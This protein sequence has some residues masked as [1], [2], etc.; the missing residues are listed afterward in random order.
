VFEQLFVAVNG[1]PVL[2][3]G[4][5][6]AT[7]VG[8][9]AVRGSHVLEL[10]TTR[11]CRAAV[12][13]LL[14]RMCREAI[15]RGSRQITFHSPATD[16]LQP[17]FD[18]AGARSAEAPGQDAPRLMAQV[19]SPAKLLREIGPLFLRRVEEANL[20]LPVQWSLAL[21]RRNYLITLDARGASVTAGKHDQHW[22]RVADRDLAPMVLGQFDWRQMRAQGRMVV[23]GELLEEIGPILFPQFTLW[24]PPLDSSA[25]MI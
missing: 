14:A 20:K 2:D 10:L 21:D 12:L 11:G 8:Y 9:A 13:P 16:Q 24:A 17:L 7:I 18:A 22:M 1:P 25:A 15:E 3:M 6:R 19:L 23:S 4:D 5:S